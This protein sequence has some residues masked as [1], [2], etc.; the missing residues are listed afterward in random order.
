MKLE[1]LIVQYLYIN[2]KVV[3]QEIGNFAISDDI[4]IPT[5]ADKDTVLPENAIQFKYDPKAGVDEG[6]INYIMENTRKIRPLA[7]S[8]LESFSMLNK[9]F[10]NIGKPLIMEGVGVLQKV[11]DGSYA[12]TQSGTSHVTVQE[13]PKMVTEKLKEKI[14][15]ATPQK[16]TSSGGGKWVILSLVGLLLIGSALAAYY[17][18]TKNKSESDTPVAANREVV[19]Q[20]KTPTTTGADTTKKADTSL[21]KTIAPKPSND[22]STFFIVIKEYQD[23]A[24]ATKRLD[25]LVSYGNKLVLTTTDSVTYKMKMPFRLPLTDTLRVKDSLSVFFQAK[26]RV[27]LP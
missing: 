17:F 19:E 16:E 11:N 2:K 10:L 18:I 12:F 20:E 25:K 15:F 27:E 3:L 4:T 9:Q 13:A 7:T 14:T 22:S 5:E 21:V 24:L 26:A 8:D 1:Q 6:L 23:L